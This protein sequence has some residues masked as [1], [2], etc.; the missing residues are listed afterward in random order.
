[1]H[2]QRLYGQP[3]CTAYQNVCA[4][5]DWNCSLGRERAGQSGLAAQEPAGSRGRREVG[6]WRKWI[7]RFEWETFVG[8][9]S[10]LIV[11]YEEMKTKTSD[12]TLWYKLSH[13]AHKNYFSL[14]RQWL[15]CIRVKKKK[16]STASY[17]IHQER[18]NMASCPLIHRTVSTSLLLLLKSTF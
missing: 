1:M 14:T 3:C 4:A 5:V 17:S 16:T 13:T 11:G 8:R 2:A 9:Q 15:S 10:D 12:Y 6:R 18:A 7:Q